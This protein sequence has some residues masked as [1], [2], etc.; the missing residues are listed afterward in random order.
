MVC[1]RNTNSSTLWSALVD[2][3]GDSRPSTSMASASAARGPSSN[4][5]VTKVEVGSSSSAAAE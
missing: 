4:P 3:L 1:S 5:D 2:L